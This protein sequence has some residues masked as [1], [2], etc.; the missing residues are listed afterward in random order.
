MIVVG[1]AFN[2]SWLVA[3]GVAPLLITALPCV[4][5]CALGLCMHKMTGRACPADDA[6]LKSGEDTDG[7]PTVPAN[8]KG[9][10]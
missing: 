5:V 8:P 1:L 10:A 9:D 7:L 3:V 6:S 4:A 2:W